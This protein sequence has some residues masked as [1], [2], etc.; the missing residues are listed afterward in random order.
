LIEELIHKADGHLIS[1]DP[2]APFYKEGTRVRI[3]KAYSDIG[4][5]DT[6]IGKEGVIDAESV[7]FNLLE[8]EIKRHN[9]YA[10]YDD[11]PGFNGPISLYC[12]ENMLEV[13]E[14][15]STVG[16]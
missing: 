14:D 16:S 12:R 6:Y 11:M 7:K 3:I 1:K 4:I 8:A 9:V 15:D 5:I 2:R 10:M 13:I